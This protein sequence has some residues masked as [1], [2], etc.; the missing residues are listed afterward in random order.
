MTE[1]PNREHMQA[2]KAAERRA[3]RAL[4]EIEYEISILRRRIEGGTVSGDDTHVIAEKVRGLT[5]FIAV[6][7]ALRDVRE[8]DAA[9]KAEAG[10]S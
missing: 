3:L 1:Y 10:R 8:W 6:L 7:E 2:D 5:S 9:D 4:S